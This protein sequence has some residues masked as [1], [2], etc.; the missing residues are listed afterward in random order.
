MTTLFVFAWG[1]LFAPP[2][3]EAPHHWK[4]TECLAAD[5][6]CLEAHDRNVVALAVT[7]GDIR[8]C[9]QAA[10]PAECAKAARDIAWNALTRH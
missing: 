2:L 3:T 8:Q 7:T 10:L 6:A 4:A 9:W 1:L 5:A